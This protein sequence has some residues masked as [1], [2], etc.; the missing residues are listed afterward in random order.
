MKMKQNWINFLIDG[1]MF[2]AFLIAT[3][4]RLSGLTIHE[5]L[6]LSLAA[7]IITHLPLHWT[8]IISIG[9]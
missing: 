1:A 6:S 9:K 2:L 5:W 8:W 4:P 7:A 3:A